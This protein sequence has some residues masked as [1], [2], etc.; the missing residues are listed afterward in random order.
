MTRLLFG[1]ILTG[2]ALLLLPC[3]GAAQ[4]PPPAQPPAQTETELVLRREVFSYPGFARRNPFVPV[5]SVATGEVSASDLR[6]V[7][8]MLDPNPRQSIA[9]L[10]NTAGLPSEYLRPGQSIGNITVVEVHRD[11]VVVDVVQFGLTDRLTIPLQS[12]APGGTE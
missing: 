1:L 12:G 10:S 9:I 11:H 2:V 6:L 7:G 4:Q 5:R 3:P 8:V